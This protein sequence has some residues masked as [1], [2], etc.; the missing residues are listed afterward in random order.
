VIAAALAGD[1]PPHRPSRGAALPALAGMPVPIKRP[2]PCRQGRT[3]CWS[4]TAAISTRWPSARP[5]RRAQAYSFVAKREFVAQPL[6]HAFLRALGTLFVE[7][8]AASK[9]AEDV[10]EIVAALGRAERW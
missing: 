10:D 2:A 3:C 8:F 6:I 5:C 7:R 9:S 4:T 1:R